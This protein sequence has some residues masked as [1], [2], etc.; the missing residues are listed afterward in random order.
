MSMRKG[1]AP[2]A[3]R[4]ADIIRLYRDEGQT[5]TAIA[6]AHGVTRTR[7][8]QILQRAGLATRDEGGT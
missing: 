2:K 3:D 1:P 7:V 6:A 4:N 5:I 8:R